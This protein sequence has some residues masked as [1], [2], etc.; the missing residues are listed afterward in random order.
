[1]IP[2]GGNMTAYNMVRFH[3]KPGH[4][5]EFLA[6]QRSVKRDFAGL[7]RGGLVKTGDCHYSFVGEWDDL[8]SIEAARPGMIANLDRVRDILEDFGDGLGVTDPESGELV[9]DVKA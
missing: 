6:V 3:V 8:K 9:L 5:Q 1:M 7:R 4:E 2:A